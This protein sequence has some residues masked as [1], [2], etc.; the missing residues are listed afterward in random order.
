[1]TPK[2]NDT[3]SRVRA[4]LADCHDACSDVTRA[5]TY[6]PGVSAIQSAME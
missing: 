2:K 5:E 4:T 6:I 3:F 1:M